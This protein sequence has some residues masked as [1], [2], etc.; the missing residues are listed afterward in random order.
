ML[1][2]SYQ[3]T[4]SER[5]ATHTKNIFFCSNPI[6]FRS[7]PGNSLQVVLHDSFAFHSFIHL[8]HDRSIANPCK[9]FSA[10]LSRSFRGVSAPTSFCQPVSSEFQ[11]L[12]LEPRPNTV[13]T[14]G[15]AREVKHRFCFSVLSADI[16]RLL[17]TMRRQAPHCTKS[18]RRSKTT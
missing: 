5:S 12:H 8:L 3:S 10:M 11:C 16:N 7:A 6:C 1:K 17:P 9:S 4:Y 18:W 13:A 2:F 14:P 15:Y